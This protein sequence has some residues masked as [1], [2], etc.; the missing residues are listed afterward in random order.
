MR[1]I[2]YIFLFALALSA[3]SCFKEVAFRTEYVLKPLRQGTAD[4]RNPAVI[5]GATAFAFGADT[6]SWTVASYDD[7]LAGI[8][9][10]KADPSVK[11]S[12]PLAASQPYVFEGGEGWISLA[13][14][15]ERQMIVAVDPV[16]RLYAYT[17]QSIGVNLSPLYVSLV[18]QPWKPGFSYRTG[19]GSGSDIWSIYNEFYAPPLSLDCFVEVRAQA[20]EGDE[21]APL[22]ASSA[23]V[24]A[25][26]VDTAAWRIASYDDA[27]NGIITSK[28]SAQTR[29]TPDFP[30]YSVS[31]EGLFGMEVSSSPLMLVVVDREH[32]MYAYTEREVDLLGASPTFT[33]LF[34][35]WVGQ[36]IVVDDGWCFVNDRLAPEE[37]EE[38]SPVSES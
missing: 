34:R 14:N 33:L 4:D 18:F 6:A 36:W 5:P 28:T 17:D 1:K 13:L 7:A 26:A 9:T 30:A 15:R 8:I 10:S 12:T 29:T 31:E 32:R 37:D 2:G 21:P 19:N 16:D 22:Q 35:P 38:Q 27:F 3:V 20:E 25:Y 23:K 11:Q 24:Y